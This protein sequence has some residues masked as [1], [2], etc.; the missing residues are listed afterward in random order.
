MGLRNN[1]VSKQGIQDVYKSVILDMG[2]KGKDT[3]VLKRR[4]RQLILKDK[5]KDRLIVAESLLRVIIKEA[6]DFQDKGMS[7]E[8]YYTVREFLDE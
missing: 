1:N 4:L 6:E 5:K 3:S 8:L 2:N 7:I